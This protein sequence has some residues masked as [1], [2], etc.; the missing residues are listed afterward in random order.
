MGEG[1]LKEF[2]IAAGTVIGATHFSSGKPNQD[3]HCVVERDDCV[4]IVVCDGC[5]EMPHSEVGAQIGARM[6]ANT[7]V[8]E[9]VITRAIPDWRFV[10]TLIAQKLRTIAET[11]VGYADQDVRWMAN[12]CLLFT[13]VAAVITPSRAAFAA[14]GDGFV[15]VNGEA[16]P[17]GPFDGNMPPYMI[18][19][20]VGSSLPRSALE[21]NV[22]RDMPTADV[23]NF[24]IGSDGVCD[25]ADL[26]DSPIP[27]RNEKI[28]PLSQFWTD[29]AFF[30]NKASLGRRLTVING[31]IVQPMFGP[32]G[33]RSAKWP[34]PLGDDTTMIAGR[35]TP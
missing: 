2:Q 24:A 34:G 17:I 26:S 28:G 4:V 35:R 25:L 20:A 1:Q 31:G 27:G 9:V 8:R 13:I 30:Q 18:Y 5:G 21:F 29:D 32:G 33:K 7:L 22:V 19:R 23:Q 11:V 12:E 3:A 16:M 14:F 10:A 15:A 6:V